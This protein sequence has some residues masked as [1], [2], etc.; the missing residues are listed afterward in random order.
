MKIL[1][2]LCLLIS[3]VLSMAF[4]IEIVGYTTSDWTSVKFDVYTLD[5]K[6]LRYDG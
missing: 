1:T 2:M 5:G 3:V 6:I 4:E